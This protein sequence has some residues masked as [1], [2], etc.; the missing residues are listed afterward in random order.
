MKFLLSQPLPP[1]LLRRQSPALKSLSA[2]TELEG[3]GE[4]YFEMEQTD[5]DGLLYAD[6]T[7][8]S[9]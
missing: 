2:G 8:I 5:V 3:P 7:R 9:K 1:Q 4:P 6:C